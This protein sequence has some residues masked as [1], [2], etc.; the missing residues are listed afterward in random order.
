M[1]KNVKVHCL[2]N[3]VTMQS[4]ANVLLAAGG[5]AVMAQDEQEVEEITAICQATL[6]NTG[7]PDERK[8][9]SCILA[10]KCA[11]R[12]GHPVV[13]DP[14]GAGAS[15]FRRKKIGQLLQSV[16]PSIIRCNQEEASALLRAEDEKEFLVLGTE[17]QKIEGT[18]ESCQ[19]DGDAVFSGIQSGGVES[20]LELELEKARRLAVRLAKKYRCTVC[21]TGEQDVISDGERVKVISGGDGRIC[22]ITGSGCMLSALCALKCGDGT[23]SFEAAAEAAETWRHCAERAGETVDEKEEGIG[24]FQIRLLDALSLKMEMERGRRM[25]VQSRMKQNKKR[26]I[27]PEQLRLYAVTDRKWL[28]EGETLETVV[29]TLVRSGVTCVQL[30]EKHASDEEIISEGKKLNEICRK[31]HVPLIVNDRPDLAKKIGAAGVHVGLSDMGIEKAHNVK[32]ALQAQKAGADYIGCGAV[33][34]SQ[35]KSDV[36]TLAKEELCAICEAVEI[37]VVAIGGITAENIKELTGTGIDGVAVVSGLFAAKDK[38]EMVRRF[39]KAFE[40]KKVLTIAGSDCSGGAGIQADLKTMAANGVYGMSAVM[41]LTAQNT[42]GVQGIMEVTPEFA[43]QQID[44][45]FTDIRPD[46]VKIG[47]L[48][49]GE[50]IHVVAEKLKEYQAEHIVLDPVMVSTSG[51]RLIQKDAE[52]SLKKELFPLAELITPNIPEAEVLSGRKIKNAQD[53]ESAAEKIVEEYG[54]AVL[55]KGGHRINDAN[56]FLCTGEKKVWI[57]GERVENPN[58]HGTGCTLSSAIAS[59]LAKGAGMEEA[60]QKAKEYLTEALKEQLD[61]GAGSGPMDH[62]LGKIIFE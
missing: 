20:S 45:I 57:C 37:P 42:T 31:H 25:E 21:M 29:E 24:S 12:L 54:C 11:N 2:T 40:M 19:Q 51:H 39:L 55:L 3:P 13:L 47:M 56:D 28:A 60:V 43:G 36:T 8:I 62:T 35:T 18:A 15:K 7:V 49:S 44:S 33:F 32:E 58:T 48:S 4:V 22:R 50:I 5:S 9:R 61:L 14:V 34:G 6:L 23:D 1:E 26:Y 30:R 27:S 52:Q 59:N 46:A 10:G 17:R 38:P 16:V 53:M 41:A